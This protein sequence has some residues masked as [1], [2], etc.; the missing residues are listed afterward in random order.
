VP[1]GYASS[2][3]LAPVEGTFPAAG[4]TSAAGTANG[5]GVS[6]RD[7]AIYRAIGD[8]V[9][10][11]RPGTRWELLTVAADTAAPFML[12]GWKTGALGGYSGT[13]QA[14]DGA[15]LARYVK[16]GEARWVVLGGEYSTRGG[17]LATQAVL[18]VCK[19]IDPRVWHSPVPY[20]YGLTLFDCAGREQALAAA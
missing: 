3:W 18:R 8:Y 10:A 20:P 13:D 14:I 15:G 19:Q 11:H 2:A 6:D 7:L 16:R 12:Q 9:R 4:P 5:F 17:N 1:T